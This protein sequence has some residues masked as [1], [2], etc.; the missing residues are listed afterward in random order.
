MNLIDLV[1][2]AVYRE[3][4]VSAIYQRNYA[5]G[6]LANGRDDWIRLASVRL[7]KP[8]PYLEDDRCS[9][10]PVRPLPCVL[11]PEHLVC[12]GTFAAQAGEDH[13]KDYHCLRRPIR[14]S[15][16]RAKV[17]AKLRSMWERENL[18]S[19]FYLFNHGSCHVDFSNLVKE[20]LAEA[21]ELEESAA[22]I[23]P[24][25]V[26]ERFFGDHLAGLQPF[27]EI[28]GKIKRL[29]DL[30]GQ[31]QLLRL[32]QDDRLVQKLMRARDDR[33]L[34]FRLVRGRLK[35]RRRSLT[36]PGFKF[37]G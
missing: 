24:N 22:R 36:T 13:F 37:C 32:F 27:S 17:M 12:E 5:L 7:K 8:C 34:V 28:R 9:I 19:S 3:E 14:L 6:L 31:G 26:L 15:P 2:A 35:A 1:G 4:M 33:A 25:Q 18:I 29:D 20:L 10:Y 30:E 21:P 16:E 23:I 11:F